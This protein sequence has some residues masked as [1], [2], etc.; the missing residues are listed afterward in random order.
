MI[1]TQTKWDVRRDLGVAKSFFT[2]VVEFNKTSSGG[3]YDYVVQ[4]MENTN[5]TRNS[6]IT[7]EIDNNNNNNNNN[8]NETKKFMLAPGQ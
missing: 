4:A 5:N 3:N 2:N 8:T 7:N 6:N 1:K